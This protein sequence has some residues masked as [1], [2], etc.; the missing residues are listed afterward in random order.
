MRSKILTTLKLSAAMLCILQFALAPSSAVFA[1]KPIDPGDHDPDGITCPISDGVVQN[2]N[3]CKLIIC[4][5][6]AA[7]TKP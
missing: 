5:R 3:N 6:D 7:S 1:L 4:H 2:G